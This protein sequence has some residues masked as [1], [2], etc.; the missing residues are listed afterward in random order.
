VDGG[1]TWALAELGESVSTYAWRAWS[2]EWDA[3]R[4]GDH[5]LSV[6]ATDGAGNTQ[7]EAQSWNREG[8][9]NNAVQSVRVVV[10]E[11]DDRVQAPA[12]EKV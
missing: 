3:T 9:Q 10:G 8:V 4:P 2:Y 12:D 5:E 7:P 1:H 6:R 11:P